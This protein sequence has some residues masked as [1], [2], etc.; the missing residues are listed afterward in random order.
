MF[1]DFSYCIDNFVIN[2]IIIVSVIGELETA[3][4]IVM[5][6]TLQLRSQSVCN[7]W[8]N[9]IGIFCFPGKND[10]SF[11]EILE[12]ILYTNFFIYMYTARMPI[13]KLQSQERCLVFSSI[14]YSAVKYSFYF[15]TLHTQSHL[16]INWN[17]SNELVRNWLFLFS[18]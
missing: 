8:K 15:M 2:F 16:V 11:D 9:M 4:F 18:Y 10:C 12:G 3:P 5:K 6:P 14:H 7:N 1:L 17:D 13:S